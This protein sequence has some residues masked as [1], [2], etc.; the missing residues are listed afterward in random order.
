M[1]SQGRR[2]TM[3]VRRIEE[4]LGAACLMLVFAAC[5]WTQVEASITGTV[6][7]SGAPLAGASVTARN[8]ETNSSRKATTDE[9]GRYSVASLP[10][11]RHEVE[12]AVLVLAKELSV[13]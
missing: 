9:A 13:Q 2:E 4:D 8:L 1:N 7:S 12:A 5:G 6:D 3:R 11:G 10:V